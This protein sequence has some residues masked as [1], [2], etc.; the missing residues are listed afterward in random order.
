MMSNMIVYL[1]VSFLS[2]GPV[3]LTALAQAEPRRLSSK[4][5]STT[6]PPWPRRSADT[7][8]LPGHAWTA[9]ATLTTCGRRGS[10]Y[11]KKR[12][13]TCRDGDFVR[14]SFTLCLNTLYQQL[15][16]L[17]SLFDVSSG[18]FALKSASQAFISQQPPCHWSPTKRHVTGAVQ[19]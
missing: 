11:A 12:S 19:A 16:D 14:K 17:F 2:T 9:R 5:S 8:T 18:V 15:E 4:D 3:R 13:F 1:C 6:Q 10:R 7:M